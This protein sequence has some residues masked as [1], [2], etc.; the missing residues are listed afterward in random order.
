MVVDVVP[1]QL[2]TTRC[3]PQYMGAM[4]ESCSLFQGVDVQI[5]LRIEYVYYL[6]V[7]CVLELEVIHQYNCDH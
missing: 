6:E 3:H 4:L 5:G 2:S 1:G 7:L